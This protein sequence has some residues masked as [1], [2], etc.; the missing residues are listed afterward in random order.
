[1]TLVA[2]AVREDGAEIVTDGLSYS[3]EG[4]DFAPVRKCHVIP[5]WNMAMAAIGPST[6]SD[7]WHSVLQECA[8][9]VRDLDELHSHTPAALREL[10]R[11]VQQ[12]ARAANVPPGEDRDSG[13]VFHVG[14]SPARGRFVAYAYR[15]SNQGVEHVD[16]TDRPV[17][18]EPEPFA[19][20]PA[21]APAS[22]K[23]WTQL[24]KAAHADWTLTAALVLERVGKVW[25]GEEVLHTRLSRGEHDQRVIHRFARKGAQWRR[26]VI[27]S[28]CPEGQMGPCW[29]GSGLPYCACH[30]AGSGRLT[31]PCPCGSLEP[32]QECHYVRPDEPRVMAYYR[33]HLR[34]YEALRAEL[35][36]SYRR[37]R[38]QEN[39]PPQQ[40]L[41]L[42]D[43]LPRP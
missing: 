4:I 7:S 13:T 3:A 17:L 19:G 27:A 11:L 31:K 36:A 5:A 24:V 38:P 43:A 40:I 15:V 26:T 22:P 23:Q 14:W 39:W 10:W 29:C 16:L 12:D 41:R 21:E 1:M 28:L 32:L 6:L 42:R 33:T 34:D 8:G 30:L 25:I 37:A 35:A 18:C 20:V 2:I 9:A